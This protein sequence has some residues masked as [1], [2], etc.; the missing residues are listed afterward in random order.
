[1]ADVLVLLLQPESGDDL[2]WEKAGVLEVAD[3]LFIHKADL[4]GAERVEAQVRTMLGLSHRPQAPILRGS[5]KSGA[6]IA[7]LWEAIEARPIRDRSTPGAQDLLRAAQE[8]LADRLTK[9][10][11]ARDPELAQLVARWRAHG[12]RLEEAVVGLLQ[13]LAGSNELSAR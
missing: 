5:A 13:L 9:A 11:A 10:E 6:G 8:L 7:E 2:Q 4:P 1:M 12:L 3:V